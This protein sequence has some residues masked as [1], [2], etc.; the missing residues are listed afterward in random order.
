MADEARLPPNLIGKRIMDAIPFGSRLAALLSQL[1]IDDITSDESYKTILRII[2]EHHDYLKDMK[3]EQ[4]FEQAIFKGR[5]RPDQS[6]SGFLASK[7]AAFNELRRQGLD[8]LETR[9]GKHLLGHLILKQGQFTDDQRQ[10]I[11]V[12]TDGS[13]DFQKVE[14]AIRKI[15]SDSLEHPGKGGGRSTYW[16]EWEADAGLEDEYDEPTYEDYLATGADE[17][18]LDI[19][20]DLLEIQAGETYTVLDEALP[21]MID[22]AEAVELAGSYLTFVYY[23][24]SDRLKGKGKGKGKFAAKGHGKGHGKGK[25]GSLGRGPRAPPGVFGVYGT[26]LDHRR[27]LR[28]SRAARGFNGVSGKGG[29]NHDPRPRVSLSELKSKTRCHQCKQI[30]QHWSREC[31]LKRRPPAPNRSSGPPSTAMFFVNPGDSSS[32]G[33]GTDLVPMCGAYMS[34]VPVFP[35]EVLA[36][37]ESL[38]T[39]LSYTFASTVDQEGHAL[40]DTAAQHGLIGA[41]T[42]KAH[43][44]LLQERYGLCVQYSGEAGGSVRGVCG[45]EHR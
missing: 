33:P 13:I 16:G 42:L 30:G 32:T 40:V 20:D 22:E 28:D 36:G 19:F 4:S 41:E 29:G 27:A 43:D 38:Q 5:R 3:L 17:E 9:A 18:E 14:S 35:K 2:E 45:A 23:E 25:K 15:F 34:E 12:L 10:R 8:L 37:F 6:I 39:Y 24:A 31:P 44:K 11:R 26:Y 7:K 21:R 1:S